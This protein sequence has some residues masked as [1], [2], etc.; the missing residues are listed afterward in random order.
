MA[1][2]ANGTEGE[3]FDVECSSCIFGDKPCPIAL[4]QNQY[5]Y[6]ACNNKVAREI[7]DHL[8]KNDGTCAMKKAF[9][10]VFDNKD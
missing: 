5:N 2:F 10:E 8:V 4:I 3:I 6:E 9:P 7:L 1:Y